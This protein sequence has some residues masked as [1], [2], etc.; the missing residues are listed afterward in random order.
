MNVPHPRH[1]ATQTCTHALASRLAPGQVARARGSMC[2]QNIEFS[3]NFICIRLLGHDGKLL[4]SAT[5]FCL[6]D[7]IL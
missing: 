4:C 2:F 1:L 7:A 6:F 3:L 5:S